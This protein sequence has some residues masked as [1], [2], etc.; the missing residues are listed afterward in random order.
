M[1]RAVLAR[2]HSCAGRIIEIEN[3]QFGRLQNVDE[4]NHFDQVHFLGTQFDAGTESMR[5]HIRYGNEGK[6]MI[7]F[8]RGALSDHIAANQEPE[9][10]PYHCIRGEM[11]PCGHSGQANRGGKSVDPDLGRL[12]WI[13]GG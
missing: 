4:P 13:F 12:V 6:A 11:F 1:L 7:T 2:N 8:T 9:G 5:G 10:A 3:D